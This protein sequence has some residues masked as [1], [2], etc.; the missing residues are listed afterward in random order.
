MSISLGVPRQAGHRRGVRV[1]ALGAKNY[2]AFL[3]PVLAVFLSV[4][5]SSSQE[6]LAHT[7]ESFLIMSKDSMKS[8]VSKVNSYARI[9]AAT[10]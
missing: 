7:S 8:S 5:L 10:C 6:G 4:T 1:L 9:A 3:A 2:G